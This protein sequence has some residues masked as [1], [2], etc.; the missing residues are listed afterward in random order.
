MAEASLQG[1][2]ESLLSSVLE[3]SEGFGNSGTVIKLLKN[4]WASLPNCNNDGLELVFQTEGN[5]LL[6]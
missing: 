6:I 1:V 2:F 5:V 4:C 3:E